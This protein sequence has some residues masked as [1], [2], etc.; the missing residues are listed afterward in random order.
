[1]EVDRN[2]SIARIIDVLIA[3]STA[4]KLSFSLSEAS[5]DFRCFDALLHAHHSGKNYW[6]HINSNVARGWVAVDS[7]D[8]DLRKG[9][10]FDPHF[11]LLRDIQ[12]DGINDEVESLEF[13]RIILVAYF[14]FEDVDKF[15]VAVLFENVVFVEDEELAAAAAG[16]EAVIAEDEVDIVAAEAAEAGIYQ[17]V[18]TVNSADTVDLIAGVAETVENSKF[19][20]EF[21]V[22]KHIVEVEDVEN[23][24][25]VV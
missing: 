4:V 3:D 24:E 12:I 19:S 2:L 23:D 20:D 8:F 13:D 22:A 1:M 6:L 17:L 11:L 18:D 21:E 15:D 10:S 25:Y 16:D 5:L 7:E 9:L 14:G